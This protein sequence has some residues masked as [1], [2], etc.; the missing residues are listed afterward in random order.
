MT[1]TFPRNDWY[2]IADA[3]GL[4]PGAVARAR[5]FGKERV[6][7]RDRDGV[8]HLWDNRCIHRGMRLHYGFVDSNRLACRYHGWRFGPHGACAFIPA[9]PAMTPPGDL[10]VPEYPLREAVGL[11]WANEGTPVADVPDPVRFGLD[12]DS[13]VFSRT[14]AVRVDAAEAAAALR[15]ART[16]A[17]GPIEV[18][19]HTG[20][21]HVLANEDG[22]VPMVL[23]IQPVEPGSA[24]IH[25]LATVR[26][27]GATEP[28][29]RRRAAA[30]AV[31]FRWYVENGRPTDMSWGGW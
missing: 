18:S 27:D 13:L 23:A 16:G 11:L 5:L 4:A 6:L 24:Q 29:A 9:H 28:A 1:E 15:G 25:V 14:I 17:G 12:P 22:N 10:R 30:W 2:A 19:V 20:G 31:R 7:W 21:L 3:G 8:A 26:P